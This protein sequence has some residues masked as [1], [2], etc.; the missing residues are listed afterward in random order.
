MQCEPDAMIGDASLR[1][2][3]GANPLAPLAGPDLAAPIRGDCRLLL[4]L[5]ALEESRLEHAH[6]LRAVLDLRALVLARYDEAARQVGDPPR[7]VGRVG[8][9]A[10]GPGRPAD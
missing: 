7:R 5:G 4:L 6:G 1:E 3:V 9:L 10:A 8:D 2:V